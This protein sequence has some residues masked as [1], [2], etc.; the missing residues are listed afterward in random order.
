M[1]WVP[2]LGRRV[3]GASRWIAYGPVGLQ[4]SE[5]AKL[6]LIVILARYGDHFQRRMS[7]FW[8]G[9]VIPGLLVSPILVLIFVEPDRGT[10]ILAAVRQRGDAGHRGRPAPLSGRAG[11]ARRGLPGL[12][13]FARL[14]AV[15][16]ASIP[17]CIWMKPAA[18]WGCRPMRPSSLSAPAA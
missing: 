3:K 6:G 13:A 2:H 10:T 4:P 9:L 12:V 17:G 16:A 5:F 18:A 1:V 8:R 14:D 15:R 11:R 7:S